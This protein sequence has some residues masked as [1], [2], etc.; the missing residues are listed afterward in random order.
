MCALK[1]K[2]FE[3]MWYG[4]QEARQTVYTPTTSQLHEESDQ[5]FQSP[6]E[7]LIIEGD[8]LEVLKV[9]QDQYTSNLKVDWGTYAYAQAF[10]ICRSTR[11]RGYPRRISSPCRT[12]VP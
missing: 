7:N 9:L 5:T 12:P 4:K 11:R 8:N 10:E 2:H 3:L 6:S 1:T